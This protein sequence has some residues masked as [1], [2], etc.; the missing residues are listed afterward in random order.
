MTVNKKWHHLW[1]C[2]SGTLVGTLKYNKC[3]VLLQ[4]NNGLISLGMYNEDESQTILMKGSV[5]EELVDSIIYETNGRN[6]L[7]CSNVF[8]TKYYFHTVVVSVCLPLYNDT[9]N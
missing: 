3:S 7:K 5:S 2:E 9:K 8:Y 4:R 1:S 6:L